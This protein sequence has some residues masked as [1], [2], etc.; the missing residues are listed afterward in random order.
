[1]HADAMM[2]HPLVLAADRYAEQVHPAPRRRREHAVSKLVAAYIAR[3]EV[4]AA[5]ALHEAPRHCGF[6][7]LRARFGE[8]TARLTAAAPEP[9]SAVNSCRH[10]DPAYP[11]LVEPAVDIGA[12]GAVADL[13]GVGR[14]RGGAPGTAEHRPQALRRGVSS[15]GWRSTGLLNRNADNVRTALCPASPRACYSISSVRAAA[16]AAPFWARRL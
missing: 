10:A 7:E 8:P 2:G 12:C 1:M 3:P 4:V 16:C 11:A 9:G 5:A 6:G 14:A 13:R 15:S